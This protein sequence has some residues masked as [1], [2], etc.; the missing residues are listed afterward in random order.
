MAATDEWRKQLYHQTHPTLRQSNGDVRLL[1]IQS[2]YDSNT[3]LDAPLKTIIQC[4]LRLANLR[5]DSLSMA[6]SHSWDASDPIV[7]SEPV[8]VDGVPVP[9]SKGLYQVL[10]HLQ[11]LSDPTTVWIDALCINHADIAEKSAQ[12]AQIAEIYAK[13]DKTLLW[14]GPEDDLS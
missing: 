10:C 6:V 5:R 9:V 8:I 2:W 11:Q 1:T 3:H 7:E 14:L 12:V 13:A 4:S